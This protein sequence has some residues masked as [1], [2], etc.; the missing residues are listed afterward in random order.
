VAQIRRHFGPDAAAEIL[1][2]SQSKV[3]MGSITDQFTRQEIVELLGR[4]EGLGP[5][6]TKQGEVMTAQ[7]LQRTTAGEGLLV[8]G[9]L[10]PVV[11]RQRRHYLDRK[12][13]RLKGTSHSSAP[14]A[15]ADAEDDRV[16]QA[17]SMEP[18]NDGPLGEESGTG[19]EEAWSGEGGWSES[20]TDADDGAV[21][22][23]PAQESA[24]PP[25]SQTGSNPEDP[26]FGE[27]GLAK[28][29]TDVEGNGAPWPEPG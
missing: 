26:W 4:Q 18:G 6:A 16:Q 15:R 13:K 9:D 28:P 25:D 7:A 11:F 29:A 5:M 12:L 20:E 23:D 8:N 10:P 27:G 21:W 17:E 1:A 14:G 3:F 2:L 19:P 22:A 24:P